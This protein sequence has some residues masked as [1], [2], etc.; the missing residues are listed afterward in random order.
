MSGARLSWLI[1]SALPVQFCAPARTNARTH[2]RTHARTWCTRARTNARTHARTHARTW[3]T[4]ARTHAVH[5]RTHAR[6]WCTHAVHKRTHAR[7]RSARTHPCTHLRTQAPAQAHMLIRLLHC[8]HFFLANQ[9][10]LRGQ[11]A[12][13]DAV[14]DPCVYDIADIVALDHSHPC[15]LSITCVTCVFL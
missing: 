14:G 2:Q 7:T 4:H 15:C 10:T 3:C 9:V 8:L 13:Y 6:T 12:C 5:T 11:S 1:R